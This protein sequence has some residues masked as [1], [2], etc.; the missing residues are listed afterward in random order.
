MVLIISLTMLNPKISVD[1]GFEIFVNKS[2]WF[3]LGNTF[4]EEDFDTMI[5]AAIKEREQY[6]VTKIKWKSIEIQ[7]LLRLY[8]IPNLFLVEFYIILCFIAAKGSSHLLLRDKSNK[9][10]KSDSY[11]EEKKFEGS[12]AK[13]TRKIQSLK[14]EIEKFKNIINQKEKNSQENEK[15]AELLSEL[16]DKGLIGTQGKI[17]DSEI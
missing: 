9:Y 16:Y 3:H 10:L 17:V 12:D 14:Q 6:I 13:S 8:L 15:Y 7:K 2:F 11:E 4:N 5:F 1:N